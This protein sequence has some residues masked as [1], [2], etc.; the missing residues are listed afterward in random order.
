M[1]VSLYVIHIVCLSLSWSLMNF[2][3][4]YSLRFVLFVTLVRQSVSKFAGNAVESLNGK[5]SPS[6]PLLSWTPSFRLSEK[7]L[8]ATN[9]ICCR[10]LLIS[11]YVICDEEIS[12]SLQKISP[13]A[14]ISYV[15]ALKVQSLFHSSLNDM[16]AWI[17]YEID[18]LHAISCHDRV[19]IGLQTSFEEFQISQCATNFQQIHLVF[20]LPSLVSPLSLMSQQDLSVALFGLPGK[21][22]EFNNIGSLISTLY[23]TSLFV[24][25]T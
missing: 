1:T 8:S 23:I 22:S 11:V 19:N 7:Y 10:A 25:N 13:R 6:E 17:L 18:L 21:L 4:K 5:I 14:L 24:Q 2:W 12:H 3:A 15:K 20:R 9:Q 16:K